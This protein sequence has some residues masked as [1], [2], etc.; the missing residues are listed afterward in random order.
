M[1]KWLLQHECI[2]SAAVAAAVEKLAIAP[3]LSSL[4][5]SESFW[6][7]LSQLFPAIVSQEEAE[8]LEYSVM[9]EDV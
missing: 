8:G 6:D 3:Q 5:S 7:G 2:S 9:L 1:I 4:T